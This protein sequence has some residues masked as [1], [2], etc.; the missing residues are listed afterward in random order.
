MKLREFKILNDYGIATLIEDPSGVKALL[1]NQK[2]VERQVIAP[3]YARATFQQPT[4][5]TLQVNE[6][7]HILLG[8]E[9]LQYTNHSCDPNAFFDTTEMQ[10]IALREIKPN[11]EITFFYPSTEWKMDQAFE[12][13]CGSPQCL[14]IIQGAYK[15]TKEQQDTYKLNNFI[16]HKIQHS[17]I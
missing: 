6:G 4:Y 9:F 12:C 8:P 10:L 2:I 15:L 14:K 1:S 5:L 11:E 13:L 7:E 3:F 16:H 17:G